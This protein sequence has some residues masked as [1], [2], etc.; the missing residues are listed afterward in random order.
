MLTRPLG[1]TGL[2]VTPLGL[3]LAALGRPGYINLGRDSDL[4]ADRAVPTLRRRA[5]EVLDAAYDAGVRYFD[6]ARSYGLAEEFLASWLQER[7]LPV[8]SVTVGSKWGYTYT[9]DWRVDAAV[10]EVKDHSLGALLRQAAESRQVLG[11]HLVLYQV[12]SATLESGI[13]E[14]RAVLAELARMRQEGLTIG[15]TLSGPDQAVVARRALAAEVDG[16]N[17]FSSVQATWNLL[18]TSAGP[19]LAEAHA[20]GWG[21]IVKEALANGRL[22]PHG[23]DPGPAALRQVAEEHQSTVD[24]VA[25]AAALAQPWADVVLSG[26]ATTAQVQSN[27][28]AA[29]LRVSTSDLARLGDL[30]G[31]PTRYWNQRRAMSWT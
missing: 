8:G 23:A 13:L 5:H 1:L 24:A 6:V 16:V 29:D 17:P 31:D 28:A 11:R 2:A 4:G 19:A 15:L 18:E 27:A 20:A 26:A 3:G 30:A 12:H 25:M 10:H 7:G 21:V 22:A 14:D 9:G